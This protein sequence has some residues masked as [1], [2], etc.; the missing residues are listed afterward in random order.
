MIGFILIGTLIVMGYVI[1]HSLRFFRYSRFYTQALV[2]SFILLLIGI[3][4]QSY[5]NQDCDE[6]RLMFYP[7][8][9]LIFLLLYK[10]S[11]NIAMKKLKRHMYYLTMWQI[12]D[13]ESSKSTLIENITQYTIFLISIFIPMAVS[14]WFVNNWY[15]C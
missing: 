10:L 11:D 8:C 6:R 7:L 4:L 3:A 1:P 5:E 13:E 15:S 14:N 9:L 2:S 12:R